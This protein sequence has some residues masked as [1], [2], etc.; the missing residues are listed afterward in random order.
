MS[1]YILKVNNVKKSFGGVHALKGVSLEIKKG[2][3]HCLAGENGCGKST[4]IKVI[5]GFHAADSGSFEIDGT[6][7]KKISL[8]NAIASGI[9]VIYQD[10]SVFPNLTVLENLAINRELMTNSPFIDWKRSDG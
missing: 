10:F 5:S 2:E 8:A 6:E 1:E 3:I 7:Y 4:L 9:Q